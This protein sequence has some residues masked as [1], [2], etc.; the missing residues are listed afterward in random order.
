MYFTHTRDRKSLC[1]RCN[2]K[3]KRDPSVV[4]HTHTDTHYGTQTK[5]Y[6]LEK[7]ARNR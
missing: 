7:K 5:T 4:A 1:K 6:N 3:C 2:E